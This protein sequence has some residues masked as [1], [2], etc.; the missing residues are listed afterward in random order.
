VPQNLHFIGEGRNERRRMKIIDIYGSASKTA[1]MTTKREDVTTPVAAAPQVHALRVQHIHT[2]PHSRT[3]VDFGPLAAIECA[4]PVYSTMV[5]THAGTRC[6]SR[7]A[8]HKSQRPGLSCRA[9][10]GIYISGTR[11]CNKPA[12]SVHGCRGWVSRRGIRIRAMFIWLGHWPLMGLVS[13]VAGGAHSL[14][15]SYRFIDH[16]SH[17]FLYAPASS[18]GWVRRLRLQGGQQHCH[19]RTTE[20]QEWRPTPTKS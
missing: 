7:K 5:A 4:A 8:E 20:T 18:G 2:T 11:A 16:E 6:A 10:L 19:Q 14:C 13:Q 3:A 1:A 12:H 17:P 15:Y 9:T